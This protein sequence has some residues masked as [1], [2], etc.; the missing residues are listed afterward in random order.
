[1]VEESTTAAE[2]LKEQADHLAV[3]IGSFKLAAAQHPH[4][5][6]ARLGQ[7]SSETF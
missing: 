3:T 1:M 6:R 4:A 5:P 7:P 2:Q